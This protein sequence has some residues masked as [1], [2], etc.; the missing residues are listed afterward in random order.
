MIRE[1]FNK[2]STPL[3]VFFLMLLLYVPSQTVCAREWFVTVE[4]GTG[5]GSFTE[6][7]ANMGNGDT[8]TVDRTTVSTITMTA[9]YTKVCSGRNMKLTFIGNNATIVNLGISFGGSAQSD[10]A[11]EVIFE[12]FRFEN[13][14][15]SAKFVRQM[16]YTNCRF[17]TNSNDAGLYGVILENG[18]Y[19]M[20]S[21]TGV[22]LFEGC[23]FEQTSKSLHFT[24]V[25]STNATSK[26]VKFVSC[27]FKNNLSNTS[28]FSSQSS[29][30]LSAEFVN[31]VL[32]DLTGS[33][34]AP[35]I[36]CYNVTSKGFNAIQGYIKTNTTNITP[37][38]ENLGWTKMETDT[39][40]ALSAEQPL[41]LVVDTYKVRYA[42]GNGLAYLRLPAAPHLLATL[43]DI[44]FPRYDLSGN[45]IDYSRPS[46]S[47]AWQSVYFADG[48]TPPIGETVATGMSITPDREIYTEQTVQINFSVQPNHAEQD[49]AWTS[50]DETIAT[51]DENGLVTVLPSDRT[52]TVTVDVT[53]TTTVARN[54]E[55]EFL[56]RTVSLTVKPY[57]HV[58]GIILDAG[59]LTVTPFVNG[60]SRTISATVEPSRPDSAALN[61]ALVWTADPDDIVSITTENGN[62]TPTIKALKAGT[63][64]LTATAE[65]NGQT[66]TYQVVVTKADYRDGMFIVNED[67]FGRSPSS[68]NYLYP[69]GSW[70]LRASS[71]ING[72]NMLGTTTQ[73]GTIYGGKFYFISK[74]GLRLSIADAQTMEWIKSFIDMGG[75]GRSFIGVDEHT[76][77]VGTASGI[78]VV[79]LDNLPD[80]P[81]NFIN[82]GTVHP[83]VVDQLPHTIISGA[84]SHNGLYSSQVATMERV[85]NYVFAIQQGVGILVINAKT[86]IVER[87][88]IDYNYHSLTLAKDGY[89]Y[90]GTTGTVSDNVVVPDDGQ[91]LESVALNII[92]RID[93]WTF[94][95]TPITLSSGISGPPA[96]WGAW[97]CPAIWAATTTNKIYW[98][99]TDKIIVCY[100]IDGNTLTKVLDL[101]DYRRHPISAADPWAFYG[102]AFRVQPGTDTLY[103]VVG[104]FYISGNIAHRNHWKVL[105]INPDGDQ[106]NADDEGAIGNIIEEYPLEDHYWFPA[107]PVFP[108]K[109]RP[110]F[111]AA[112]F[113][114]NIPLNGNHPADSL[115]LTDKVTDADNMRASIVTTVADGY[116]KSLVNAYIWRDTLVVAARKSIPEGQPAESTTLT[117]RFNS[118]G[119][120]ITKAVGVTVQPGV[121]A[122]APPVV[123]YP[124]E[125]NLHTLSVSS[126]QTEQLSL[127]YPLGYTVNW[128]SENANVATVNNAGEVT[129]VGEGR[130]Q[131]I[132]EDLAQGKSDT[133]TVT[134]LPA[135]VLNP[136]ELNADSLT[137][138]IAQMA[139]LQIT[140]PEQYNVAWQSLNENIAIVSNTGKVVALAAGTTRI[141]ASDTSKGKQ[142]ECVVTVLG[143]QS[144]Y[145][146]K[147]NHSMLVM[148]QGDRATLSVSSATD[149]TV[150]W[151]SNNPQVV[152][153]TSGGTIIAFM[154]GNAVITAKLSDGK[155]SATC[156]VTVRETAVSITTSDVGTHSATLSFP[157][158]V[159]TDYYLVHLYR[160]SG[161]VR[162]PEVAIK[163]N[164]NG[165]VANVINLRADDDNI[166]LVVNDL[167]PASKYEAEIDVLREINGT[168]EATAKLSISFTTQQETGLAVTAAP[169]AAVWYAAGVL[170][171]RNLEGYHYRIASVGGQVLIAS[172]A[173]SD[174]ETRFVSLPPGVY[175]L[176]AQK[177]SERLIFKFAAF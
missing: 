74:Q 129:G 166:C 111:T 121:V 42:G 119:H 133:C 2:K 88:L 80:I 151:S 175:I 73:F 99:T 25:T 114:E 28:L 1:I 38:S 164:P 171:L 105:K 149:A 165:T 154:P 77:Y 16:R 32:I 13:P 59:E 89:L 176:T 112:A 35:T 97:Q 101:N 156:S 96:S 144:T 116:D 64:I 103:A 161:D 66:E 58:S 158:L 52:E 131:I 71:W 72:D 107:M 54:A 125:L 146:V 128:R 41:M 130:T 138:D 109:H 126:G 140:A 174:E 48:E 127:V 63:T 3:C 9:I 30:K 148:N 118:N 98:K 83:K 10:A 50:S 39:I 6:A 51:V 31:C 85:G 110:E 142:D 169:D 90:A 62:A 14:Y 57:I 19:N 120:V 55:G 81:G 11:D 27:T 49:V 82:N 135:V 56:S 167:S 84:E 117:L 61:P 65:D 124:L 159:N 79:N 5:E 92:V 86:H 15:L 108:D 170:R 23:V 34:S 168:V 152:D 75:D 76:G 47:G 7:L 106:P 115:N 160:I 123:D 87:T 91:G 67:W 43:A 22:S 147:L 132:A 137:L 44:S 177:G 136:F 162:Q 173:V 45:E 20:S 157:K 26:A 4:T 36:N 29:P 150:S 8:V 104:T 102:T 21:A 163:V 145:A 69:N 33:N 153:V 122:I 70:D 143:A 113:P 17:I 155:D 18:I 100:D 60:Y 53:A 68:L 134:V 95:E 141:I 12:N 94:T 37:G 46:H 24:V 78:R 172:K 139:Q 40:I 93:P